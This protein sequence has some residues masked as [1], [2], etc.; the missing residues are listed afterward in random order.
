MTPPFTIRRTARGWTILDG[1][2]HAVCRDTTSAGDAK[3][4]ARGQQVCRAL[5]RELAGVQMANLCFNLSQRD[6]EHAATMRILARE[7]DQA[8]PAPEAQS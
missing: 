5:N 6:H 1:D 3:G 8:A 2:G 7:W 4:W